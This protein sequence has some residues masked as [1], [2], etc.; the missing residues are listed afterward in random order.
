[1]AADACAIVHAATALPGT[2]SGELAA[3]MLAL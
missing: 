1:V 2:G 3:A